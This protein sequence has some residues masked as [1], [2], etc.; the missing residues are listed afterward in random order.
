MKNKFLQIN[1]MQYLHYLLSRKIV[2]FS[3][4]DSITV[5]L[6]R[7]LKKSA[8]VNLQQQEGNG[9]TTGLATYII[10]RPNCY[11]IKIGPSYGMKNIFSEMIFLMSGEP[12]GS[13]ISIWE[14]VKRLAEILTK[15]R[16]EKKLVCIDDCTHLSFRQ[17][18]YFQELRDLTIE[19][20]A[21]VFIS[22]P[23]FQDRL[24]KAIG[25][26]AGVG[27]FYRRVQG[28]V[29]LPGLTRGDIVKYCDEKK[30][31]KDEMALVGDIKTIASLE[32]EV[33]KIIDAREFK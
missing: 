15:N 19:N 2:D 20:T 17:L 7:A 9:K 21:F 18:S 24:K 13:Y 8:M 12:I 31:T 14:M 27:E 32:T 28:F 33:D 25:K 5:S 10:G 29:K 26:V 30:V 23:I 3:I 16:N 1:S 22:P 11:Y 6:D 4:Q